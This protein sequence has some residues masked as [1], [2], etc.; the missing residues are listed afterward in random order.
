[1]NNME[2]SGTF[3]NPLSHEDHV[4]DKGQFIASVDTIYLPGASLA[5]AGQPQ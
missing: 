3:L 5:Q 1:M 2:D 4:D